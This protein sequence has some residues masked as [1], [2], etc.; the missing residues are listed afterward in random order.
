MRC[1]ECLERTWTI[2]CV[3]EVAISAKEYGNL[4][5]GR[6]NGGNFGIDLLPGLLKAT[7]SL[8][9]KA[10]CRQLLR[11]ELYHLRFQC[12]RLAIMHQDRSHW[13][14]QATYFLQ[15]VL[16]GGTALVVWFGHRHVFYQGGYTFLVI[17]MRS[18][19]ECVCS[20][21]G[22][23]RSITVRF[24]SKAETFSKLPTI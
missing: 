17:G 24:R 19:I 10:I 14:R 3:F 16:L 21:C 12:E 6:I 5:N 11:D 9:I 7:N 22:C 2:E 8:A 15:Q 13:G 1:A 20:V 18:G 4:D 23:S